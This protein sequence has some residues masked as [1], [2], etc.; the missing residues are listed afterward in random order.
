MAEAGASAWGTA[1]PR[2]GPHPACLALTR[3]L[4]RMS[5]HALLTANQGKCECES[6]AGAGTPTIEVS[7]AKLSQLCTRDANIG[8]CYVS[9]R[10]WEQQWELPL[11]T[12]WAGEAALIS[13]RSTPTCTQALRDPHACQPV[14]PQSPAGP[15]RAPQ[16]SFELPVTSGCS[17]THLPLA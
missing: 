14:R 8:V 11:Q 13:S 2:W 3:R 17:L 12:A 10:Q 4:L 9:K 5:P 6:I 7:A 1:R 15:R 16:R